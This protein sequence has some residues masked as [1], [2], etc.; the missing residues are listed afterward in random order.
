ME[1]GERLGNA[2]KRYEKQSDR[3]MK[4]S[5]DARNRYRVGT[6]VVLFFT[7]ATPIAVLAWPTWVVLHAA[8]P[9]MAG[10]IAGIMAFL[11]EKEQWHRRVIALTSLQRE[12]TLFIT[13]SGRYLGLSDDDAI[14]A[15][16]QNMESIIQAEVSGWEA[17]MHNLDNVQENRKGGCQRKQAPGRQDQ[18]QL[19]A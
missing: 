4:Q 19:P 3:Y 13:R 15:F 12:H 14:S 8:L 10:L 17:L 2:I 11:N 16:V 7:G 9:A 18:G 5:G 1:T 6:G